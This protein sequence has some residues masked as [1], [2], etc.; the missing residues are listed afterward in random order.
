MVRQLEIT[1][2]WEAFDSMKN[3]SE[4]KHMY[5]VQINTLNKK[6][7]WGG[8]L[9]P[10]DGQTKE[11]YY[12]DTGDSFK[13]RSIEDELKAISY[14]RKETKAYTPRLNDKGLA[15]K[16]VRDLPILGTKV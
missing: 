16:W 5:G 4:E 8:S 9:L 6:L 10:I 1:L 13:V 15:I 2:G 7:R 11:L 3:A 14:E 12:R